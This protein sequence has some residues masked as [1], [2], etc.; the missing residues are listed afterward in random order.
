MKKYFAVWL[1]LVMSMP[2]Y[3]DTKDTVSD[4]TRS[5]V[6][7]GKELFGGVNDGVDQGRAQSEGVDGAVVVTDLQGLNQ[8]VD[9]EILRVTAQADAPRTVIEV[10]FK[11]KTD[12]P[13]RIANLDDQGVVLVIDK[14]GYAT[15]LT[16]SSLHGAELTVPPKAGLKHRFEFDAP[17]SELN[18]LRLW[19]QSYDLPAAGQ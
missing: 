14:S 1:C 15:G 18:G 11:N 6:T 2:V 7:F 12:K 4:V 9:V 19:Q 5:V 10:G 13:V 3:A 16:R 8:H 17:L